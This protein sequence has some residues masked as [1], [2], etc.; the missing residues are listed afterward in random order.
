MSGNMID[1]IK[2]EIEQSGFPLELYVI[3]TCSKKNTGRLPNIRYTHEGTLREIDLYAFFEEIDLDPKGGENLQHTK[4]AMIIECK[5]SKDKPWVFFSASMHQSKDVSSFTKYVSDFDLY[6]NRE[7]TYPLMGQIYKNLS[8]YHYKDK[9]IPQCITY[10]EA[11]KNP[12]IP[13]EIYK[14]IDSVLSFLVYMNGSRISRCNEFGSYTEFFFP[15]IVFDGHLFEAIAEGNE[16]NVKEQNHIQLRTDYNEEIFIIDFVKKEYFEKF[17]E[18]IEKDHLEF[19][20]SI[21]KIHFSEEYTSKLKTTYEREM[22]E[23]KTHFPL[24]MYLE[25]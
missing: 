12:S 15:I 14:A 1:K 6:F 20:T 22:K 19:V 11:F 21:N 7:K 9:R 23:Y 2:K 13:S 16:I 24:E 3:N 4:T 10:F 8:T 25:E 18:L 17:F 5:K